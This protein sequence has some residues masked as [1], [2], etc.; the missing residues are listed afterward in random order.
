MRMNMPELANDIASS[1]LK[2]AV[3]VLVPA[4]YSSKNRL[5]FEK[6]MQ[7]K[8]RPGLLVSLLLHAV[9]LAGF[10][11]FT[12]QAP[13]PKVEEVPMTVSLISEIPEAPIVDKQPEP[14]QKQVTPK[15]QPK[16]QTI[17]QPKLQP[18]PE[19]LPTQA[20]TDI[21]SPV[22]AADPVEANVKQNTIAESQPT[23]MVAKAPV[24]KQASKEEVTEPPK[25][26]VAY[27]NNP[28]PKYPRLSK[29]AGEEGRVS[30]KVLVNE[31]G[32][33]ESVEISAGS[34][35][36]RLDN[37]AMEAVQHWKFVPAK[38]N[39]QA[40]SAYVTVPISFKLD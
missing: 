40:I 17:P 14:L 18:L 13:I 8:L 27:L 29:S 20:V 26:G 28:K 34:G 21:P 11:W 2:R 33:P 31:N 22:V 15:M 32:D 25:F 1:E 23:E 9:A 7:H 10:A 24:E 6:S 37:A 36:E 4:A 35:F 19:Q 38:R 30:F 16:K 5:V 39:N 3:R 12:K